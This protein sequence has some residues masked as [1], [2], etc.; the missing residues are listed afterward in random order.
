M[1]NIEWEMTSRKD[2]EAGYL[3][4]T[5]FSKPKPNIIIAGGA[6]KNEVKVF[7]NNADGS[8]TFRTLCQI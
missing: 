7:E 2:L 1:N 8:G 5:R 6:G 3:Y 4:A